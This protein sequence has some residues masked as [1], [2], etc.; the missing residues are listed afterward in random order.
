MTHQ[1]SIVSPSNISQILANRLKYKS[2][3]T[4]KSIYKRNTVERGGY[5]VNKA[6]SLYFLTNN[7]KKKITISLTKLPMAKNKN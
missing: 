3:T 1:K 4:Q 2:F 7:V 5:F 6:R